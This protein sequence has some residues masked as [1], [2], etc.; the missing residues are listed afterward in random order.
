MEPLGNEAG[1]AAILENGRQHTFYHI[2]ATVCPFVTNSDSKCSD[3]YSSTDK[4][5]KNESSLICLK[6]LGLKQ[7]S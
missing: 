5:F 1:F 7:G 4:S 3:M 2:S 6:K